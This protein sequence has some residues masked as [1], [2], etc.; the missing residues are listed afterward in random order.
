MKCYDC[1]NCPLSWAEVSYEGECDDCG[2]MVYDD[3]YGDKLICQ[4]PMKI[5]R[6]IYKYKTAKLEKEEAK[7]YDGI[8]EWYAEQ[9]R[10][11]NAMRQALNEKLLLNRFGKKLYLCYKSELD[12]KLY[13]YGGLIDSEQAYNVLQ[14]Y[15]EL[16]ENSEN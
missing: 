13:Q 12:N 6:W 16:L 4:M 7:R 2:C 1:E 10:K 11:E 14:R 9:E 3:L 5:K 15:E 8:V